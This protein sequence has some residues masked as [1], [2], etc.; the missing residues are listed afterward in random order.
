M[1][2]WVYEKRAIVY[3]ETEQG[4]VPGIY[5]NNATSYI[6]AV[7]SNNLYLAGEK[8]RLDVGLRFLSASDGTPKA[9]GTDSEFSVQ[10]TYK[11]A[12]NNRTFFN[13]TIYR[14]APATMGAL[15]ETLK[16][17]E[18]TYPD[19]G[20]SGSYWYVKTKRAFPAIRVIAGGSV[21]TCTEG[22]V[23]VGGTLKR[24]T[25]AY[26]VVGGALKQII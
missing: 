13:G 6:V 12:A 25:A 10:V 7:P 5:Y 1:A 16:A 4:N 18:G 22:F 3:N 23:V 9:F 14:A 2:K 24:I 21:K 15:I 20:I 26:T 17:E 19:N 11:G 8:K